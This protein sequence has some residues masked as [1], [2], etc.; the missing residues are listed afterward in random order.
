[1][2]PCVRHVSVGLNSVHCK[3]SLSV[4]A[5]KGRRS[6]TQ[7][8]IG[9]IFMNIK[10]LAHSNCIK[11]SESPLGQFAVNLTNP[12][13]VIQWTDTLLA[14]IVNRYMDSIDCFFRFELW[15]CFLP[16][17][18]ST[19]I[20]DA[21]CLVLMSLITFKLKCYIRRQRKTSDV[22]F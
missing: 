4:L 14:F 17:W 1:M 11:S 3:G 16:V 21:G 13:G 19:L 9:K 18:S 10:S 12:F 2:C 6:S 20:A 22:F 5:Q 8:I 15:F 7:C